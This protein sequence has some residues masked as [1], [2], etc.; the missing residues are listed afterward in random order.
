MG[1][2][3]VN[4]KRVM[5]IILVMIWMIIIFLFSNQ[6]G[7]GSG[8]TSKNVSRIIA[9]IIDIQKEYTEEQKEELIQT[10]EPYI[11]KLAHFSIYTLGGILIIN[12]TKQFELI[13]RKQILTSVSIGMLYAITDELHQ[14]WIAGRSR[15]NRRCFNRYVRGIDWHNC[16]FIS[17]RNY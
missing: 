10:I 5:S 2:F 6:Q 9:N 4:I 14:L 16:I 15:K 8:S 1:E 11:R 13:N 12:A 17:R 7:E 3:L